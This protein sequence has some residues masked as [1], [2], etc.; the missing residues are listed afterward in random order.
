MNIVNFCF[1]FLFLLVLCST[2]VTIGRSLH[3][4]MFRNWACA[5]SFLLVAPSLSNMPACYL[6]RLDAGSLKHS[7]SVVQLVRAWQAICEVTGLSPFL[8]HCHFL[9]SFFHVFISHFS[10][11]NLTWLR[12]DGQVWNMFKIWACASRFKLIAPNF[13]FFF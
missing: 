2:A 12:T 13:F 8:S 11:L 9:P 4:H 1:Q 7:N 5:S 6:L 10:F 3:W